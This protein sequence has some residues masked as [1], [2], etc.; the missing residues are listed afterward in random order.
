M[1]FSPGAILYQIS[2]TA[3]FFKALVTIVYL[4][5]PWQYFKITCKHH[6][7]QIILADKGTRLSEVQ[8]Q[9]AWEYNSVSRE[10]DSSELCAIH[11]A[12]IQL[13]CSLEHSWGKI[14]SFVELSGNGTVF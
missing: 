3:I 4:F 2:P 1:W 9:L 11:V 6:T 8:R 13:A 12:D 10:E 14:S 7:A 5:T